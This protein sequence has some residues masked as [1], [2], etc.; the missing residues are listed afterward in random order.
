M[1][2]G[3]YSCDAELAAYRQQNPR[4][5]ARFASAQKVLAGGNS[6]L[7]AFFSPFPFY[8]ERGEGCRLYDLD[9]NERLDFYNNATSLILGL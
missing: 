3:P 4:S 5:A 7:T 8:V 1:T 9:G 6:R 2:A